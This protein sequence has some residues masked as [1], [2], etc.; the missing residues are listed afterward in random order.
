VSVGDNSTGESLPPR[1]M[2]AKL[3]TGTETP[4]ISEQEFEPNIFIYD[5]YPGG[6]GLSPGLFSLEE[7][8]L[9]HC[10]ETILACPCSAGCPSCVGPTNESGE[11]AKQV[12]VE[13]LNGILQR[14]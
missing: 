6:I 13:I 8:L 1:N 9:Q 10:L 11:Q 12:A 2:P 7:K 5:N 4:E 3:D 14:T